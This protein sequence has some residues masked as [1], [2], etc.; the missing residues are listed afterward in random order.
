M[1][2]VSSPAG[3]QVPGLGARRV[4]H[5]SLASGGLSPHRSPLS[6]KGRP[7]GTGDKVLFEALLSFRDPGPQEG[8]LAAPRGAQSQFWDFV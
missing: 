1:T 7:C 5:V 4:R 2:E 6:R 8:K 3:C